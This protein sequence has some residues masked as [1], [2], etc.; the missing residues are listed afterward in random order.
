MTAR[1]I[2]V[3]QHPHDKDAREVSFA[4][5]AGMSDWV[6]ADRYDEVYVPY[7]PYVLTPVE[8]P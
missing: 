7:V 5:K 6:Y 4:D 8:L 2:W 3:A 1:L